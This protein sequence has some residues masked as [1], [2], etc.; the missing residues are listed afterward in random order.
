MQELYTA[1]NVI[2]VGRAGQIILRDKPGVFHVRVIAPA[3]FRATRIAERQNISIENA[4]AQI[5][6]SDKNRRKFVRRFFD[7]DWNS[8]EYYDLVINTTHLTASE[9]A[10][11]IVQAV[12]PPVSETY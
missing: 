9:S 5:A 2:I 7:I 12:T 11:L 3:E 4:T 6:A 10:K 8:P 1:G